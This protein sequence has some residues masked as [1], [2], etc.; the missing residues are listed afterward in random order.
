MNSNTVIGFKPF[1]IKIAAIAMSIC[2][3]F[4]PSH[5]QVN[6]FLHSVI[7]QLEMPDMVI[8]HN[9]ADNL[10]HHIGHDFS[11]VK[12]DS[13]DHKI[14]NIIDNVL[15]ASNTENDSK[16]SEIASVKIDKHIRIYEIIKS[17]NDLSY[18]LLKKEFKSTKEKI[19]KGFTRE[20][21]DPPI[22]V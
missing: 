12:E 5:H 20:S 8:S 4:G 7:H 15:E 2:Y 11:H 21:I 1:I 18:K 22:T 16:N 14:L 13:H 19:L 17:Q 9:Q 6:Q 10:K 3:V